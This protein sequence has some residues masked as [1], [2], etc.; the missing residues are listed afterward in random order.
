MTRELE[1]ICEEV[2]ELMELDMDNEAI[3]LLRAAIHSYPDEPILYEGMGDAFVNLKMGK[4][5]YNAY[6]VAHMMCPE[7]VDVIVGLANACLTMGHLGEAERYIDLADTLD[8][9][10]ADTRLS[11]GYLYEARGWNQDASQLYAEILKRTPRTSSSAPGMDTLLN[12][13]ECM[14]KRCGRFPGM[15]TPARRT[16]IGRSSWVIA[17]DLWAWLMSHTRYS[18]ILH[19]PT[20]TTPGLVRTMH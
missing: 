7:D 15:S 14:T 6:M 19:R 20:R 16:C 9:E 17:M 1:A 13:G 2:D 8:P 10:N 5:A 3:V 4:E 18:K 11:R 12:C